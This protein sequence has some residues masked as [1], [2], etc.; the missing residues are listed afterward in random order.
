MSYKKWALENIRKKERLTVSQWADKYRILPSTTSSEAGRWRTARTPYLKEIM[1]E[2]SITSDTQKVV[3]IK[4]T[5]IGATEASSNL[6]GYF[7]HHAPCPIGF[8]QPTDNLA[9]KHAKQKLWKMR[10]ESPVLKERVADRRSKD[11]A[12]T[13]REWSFPGGTLSIAGSNSSASFRSSSYKVVILDD[14]DGFADD[15]EGEGSPIDLAINRADSFPDR[16]IYINSTPTVKG[17]SHIEA[18]YE[19]TDQREYYV[20]CPECDFMQTLVW[21]NIIFE[22]DGISIIGE[23]QYKCCNCGS[24]ISENKKTWMLERGEWIPKYPERRHKGYKIPSLLSPLGWVSWADIAE[25]FLKAT[26]KARKGD[27]RGLK[28][29]VN[30][31]LA[32]AFE[33]QGTQVELEYLEK[34][35]EYY[36]AD[37]PDGVLVLTAGVDCQDDRLELVVLGFGAGKEMWA[38]EYKQLMGDTTQTAVWQQLDEYLNRKWAF[39]DGREIGISCTCIDSGG[40]STSEVYHYCK[41]REHRRIFAVKGRG[42]E[43]IPLVGKYSRSNKMNVALF[44][45]GDDE[46][47]TLILSRL[48][49]DQEG[50]GYI[51][52]PRNK[53]KGFDTEY[54]KGLVSEK[55]VKK[56]VKGHLKFE[57]IK[58]AGVR[59][60]PID[61]MKYGLAALEI[62]NPNFQV[63]KRYF[64]ENK[65]F[66]KHD[67]ANKGTSGGRKKIISKGIN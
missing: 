39:K 29:F 8:W 41:P 33:E 2:L 10:E 28:K 60:E 5:Q 12:S 61:T 57:W 56:Y 26:D 43:G 53:E 65:D 49:V 18:E 50:E 13:I 4:G 51:H 24:L 37:V 59:N 38:I 48:M 25:E 3:V 7:I 6:I 1:D 30:T 40:H 36:E 67:Q 42:G 45:V 35:R 55:K 14:I 17:V 15:V 9:E 63:I 23:A 58:E 22:K 20:P 21:S 66:Y 62:L 19:V 11:G 47:K 34:R 54:F 52:F 64:D 27:K 16:K 31:R 44:P 32:E 46:S